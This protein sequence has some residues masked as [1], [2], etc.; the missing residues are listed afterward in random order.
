MSWLKVL[1]SNAVLSCVWSWIFTT[2]L[3]LFYWYKY[4][5]MK[6]I[7]ILSYW[8]MK[9]VNIRNGLFFSWSKS[10][11]LTY[12][13][14]QN[15]GKKEY[16]VKQNKSLMHFVCQ[17]NVQ[18]FKLKMHFKTFYI[19][20][21]SSPLLR[22]FILLIKE[23]GKTQIFAIKFLFQSVLSEQTSYKILFFQ[24]HKWITITLGTLGLKSLLTYG[25]FW[26]ELVVQR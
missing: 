6:P 16:Y 8:K 21:F 3:R 9:I 26:H 17:T 24:I 18:I 5:R 12:K 23:H 19:N 15:R 25:H 10:S 4:F 20:F 13:S 1:L 11:S 14:N 2:W 7:L 22:L